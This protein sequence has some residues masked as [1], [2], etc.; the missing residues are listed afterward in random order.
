MRVS[1]LLNTVILSETASRNF[2]MG[3]E[4]LQGQTEGLKR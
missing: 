4:Q 1:G 3:M 2:E